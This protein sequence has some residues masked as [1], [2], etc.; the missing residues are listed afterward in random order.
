MPSPPVRYHA[1][2]PVVTLTMDQQETR[3]ALTAELM[4]GVAGGL[5]R[6]AS[7]PGARVVVLGAAGPTFCA[8]ADLRSGR[9]PTGGAVDLG[10]LMA[11]L[12]ALPLP[13]ICRVEGHCLGGGMGLIAACD[14]AVANEEVRLGFTEVR[15]G[16]APAIVS[17]TCLP[18]LRRADA[19]ELFLTGERVTAARAADMGLINRAVPAG[20]VDSVVSAWVD[21]ITSGGPKAVA[22]AKGLVLAHPTEPAVL[23]SLSAELFASAEAEEGRA[24]FRQRRRPAWATD[25]GTGVAADS[26]EAPAAD[27]G[28]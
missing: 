8:G 23:A 26:G 1:N 2:G 6:A 24:A 14:L 9:A 15:L 13:V 4:A 11:A 7:Q 12:Q 27:T 18:R 16:V 17:T 20:E 19:L 21:A 3:N 5:A 28:G 22:A 25:P 10:G